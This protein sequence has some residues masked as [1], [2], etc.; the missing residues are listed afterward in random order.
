MMDELHKL[1]IAEV[2]AE[3]FDCAKSKGWHDTHDGVPRTLET[4]LLLMHTE[5]SEAVEELRA[6]QDATEIYY[7]TDKYGE[8]K[9]EGVPVELADLVIRVCESSE[10]RGIPLLR[11]IVEKMAYN[12]T[13]PHRHGGKS[14]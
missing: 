10:K 6:G 14:F 7:V 3:A 13:R 5:L 11:A 12:R 1:T 9:P 4:E 8:E 2:Q